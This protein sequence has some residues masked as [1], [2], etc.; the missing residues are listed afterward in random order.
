M[1]MN[2]RKRMYVSVCV[3]VCVCAHMHV[4]HRGPTEPVPRCLMW[5]HCHHQHCVFP[6]LGIEQDD[7]THD[8]CG[9]GTIRPSIRAPT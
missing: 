1:E 3:L 4:S 9:A 8:T 7:N 5:A 6:Y 2:L